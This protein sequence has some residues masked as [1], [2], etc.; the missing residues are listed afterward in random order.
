MWIWWR[1]CYHRLPAYCLLYTS[2]ESL[3]ED[4]DI[5]RIEERLVQQTVVHQEHWHGTDDGTTEYKW[6]KH[7]RIQDD[8]STEENRFIDTEQ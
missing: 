6:N 7:D 1:H 4:A 8:R 2:Q 5:R 3:Q